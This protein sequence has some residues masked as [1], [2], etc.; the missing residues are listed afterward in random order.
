MHLHVSWIPVT[1]DVSKL[2]FSPLSLSR[3]GWATKSRWPCPKAADHPLDGT[4]THSLSL[5]PAPQNEE[6]ISHLLTDQIKQ[7]HECGCFVFRQ[8]S[9]HCHYHLFLCLLLSDFALGLSAAL[10][11]SSCHQGIKVMADPPVHGRF[12]C[13]KPSA[14]MSNLCSTVSTNSWEPFPTV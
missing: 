8:V 7:D 1:M 6:Q 13:S 5:L 9:G 4:T 12:T 11:S 2:A 10:L 3:F 14:T